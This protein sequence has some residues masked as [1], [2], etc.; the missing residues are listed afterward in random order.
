[1]SKC[2]ILYVD[3]RTKD[4][5]T[6]E[7]LETYVDLHMPTGVDDS[8]ERQSKSAPKRIF[9]ANGNGLKNVFFL[10]TREQKIVHIGYVTQA[11]V[12]YHYQT[13]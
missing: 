4:V 1:M 7:V 9:S 11:L 12:C 10:T 13:K 8:R 3:L 6:M 5:H 2:Y